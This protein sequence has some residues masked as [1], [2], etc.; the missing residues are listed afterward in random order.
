[1]ELGNKI[2]TG[3]RGDK[4][5]WAI[6]IILAV[7]S[8]LVVYSST[9]R[10]A[11]EQRGGNTEF[12]LIKQTM[13]VGFG[14]FLTWACYSWN[15]INYS[16]L[17]PILV[18]IAIPLLVYTLAFGLEI[19]NAK[20]WIGMPGVP[21]TFQ[22]SEFAKLALIIFIARTISAKQEYIADFKSAF[23]PIIFPVL[24]ICLLIA[25]S[26]LSSALLLFATSILMMFMG[27]VNAKYIILL[28]FLGIV[29]FACLIIA[30]EFLPED[31]RVDTW[32]ARVKDFMTDADGGYQVAQAKIAIAQGELSGLGPGNSIQRNY[33]PAPY[34]DFVY[35]I[36][37]EEYGLIL[38]GLGVLGLYVLL[39]FRCVR[40]VTKSAK[41][42]GAMVALGI[43]LNIVLQALANMAVSVNLVPVT[44][45]TLPMISMGGTSI[46][47]S[48]IAFGII[49]SVS[50]F[51]EKAV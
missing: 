16:K 46:L 33:L 23:L 17:A 32:T 11:Y 18:V 26:D 36:I 5:V 3:L 22:T 40:M 15:Y 10:I 44:G 45:L 27:R 41:T 43:S 50:R 12:Y 34:S 25:P 4:V 39:F 48:S 31:I 21:I 42:F 51:I 1:M 29:A 9:G 2:F 8:I 14:L 7:V 38:G 30:G 13:L 6:V 35:A 49:L 24:V 28:F 19:N 20:R 37:I 47:F